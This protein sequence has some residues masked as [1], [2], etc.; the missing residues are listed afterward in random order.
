VRWGWDG[1]AQIIQ[2][3]ARGAGRDARFTMSKRKHAGQMEPVP[4]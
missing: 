3:R 4:A 1:S 2:F